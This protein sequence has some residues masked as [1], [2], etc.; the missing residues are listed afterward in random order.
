MFESNLQSVREVDTGAVAT[1]VWLRVITGQQRII[2]FRIAGQ[3]I[4]ILASN[5]DNCVTSYE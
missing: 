1:W 4:A 5:S 3:V 2:C